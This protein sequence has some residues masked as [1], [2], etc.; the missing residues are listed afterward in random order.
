M[1]SINQYIC[2]FSLTLL[3]I[4]SI[5]QSQAHV[6]IAQH[7]TL[8]IHDNIVFMVL[9]LPVSAF[10]G[11]DDDGD[12]KLSE[13]EFDKHEATI[14][15]SIIKNVSIT[16]KVSKRAVQ[17]IKLSRV[18]PHFSLDKTASELVV[19]ARFTLDDANNALL[20]QFN[21][22]AKE[23]EKQFLIIT[24]TRHSD[25]QQQVFELTPKHSSESFFSE[26]KY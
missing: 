20:F 2:V 24:A 4:I 1:K 19:K 26:T 7:G 9:S 6:M 16:D 21:L 23:P 14:K 18:T 12:G 5:G 22:F 15:A 8:N 25:K 17:E 10:K 11:I 13:N 3:S